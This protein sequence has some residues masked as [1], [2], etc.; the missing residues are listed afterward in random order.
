M[1][2]CVRRSNLVFDFFQQCGSAYGV[3]QRFAKEKLDFPKRSYGGTW[4]GKL[5]LG[6]AHRCTCHSHLEESLVRWSLCVRSLSIDQRDSGKRR[7]PIS[8]INCMPEEN[9]LVNLRDHHEGYVTF[10]QYTNNLD[11]LSRN[12]TNTK[13]TVLSGPAR[14]GLALLQGLLICGCCG[15]RVTP[16]LPRKRRHLSNVSM[17]LAK[18]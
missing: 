9:W 13:E 12:Q 8:R 15:R 16:A 18:T 7:S 3:V 1:L 5:H 10:E 6:T 14:E 4:A 11:Q 2:T 17:Q